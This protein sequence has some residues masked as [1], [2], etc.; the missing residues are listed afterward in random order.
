MY[1]CIYILEGIW[2][3][4][5]PPFAFVSGVLIMALIGEPV[6]TPPPNHSWLSLH[7]PGYL[8][9]KVELSTGPNS[10]L[11]ALEGVWGRGCKEACRNRTILES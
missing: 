1:R 7:L 6:A 3:T 2:D 9:E 10:A 4:F 11:R 5:L 8:A